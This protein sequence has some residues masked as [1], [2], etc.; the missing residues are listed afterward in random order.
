[1]KLPMNQ[2]EIECQVYLEL[3]I[4]LEKHLVTHGVASYGPE[5]EA[6]KRDLDKYKEK[7]YAIL[8]EL[9]REVHT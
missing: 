4:D 5:R 9:G 6:R 1:M 2:K 3:I 7:Y 8:S